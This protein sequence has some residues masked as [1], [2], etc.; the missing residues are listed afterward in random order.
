MPP[1][2]LLTH[3]LMN[4]KKNPG[5]GTEGRIWLIPRAA[6]FVLFRFY[7]QDYKLLKSTALSGGK[8]DT[9]SILTPKSPPQSCPGPGTWGR[10]QP[11]SSKS[12]PFCI[13]W[14]LV[15]SCPFLPHK[16]VLNED[17][18]KEKGAWR[19]SEITFCGFS[20]GAPPKFHRFLNAPLNRGNILPNARTHCYPGFQMDPTGCDSKAVP[21]VVSIF[22]VYR[23]QTNNNLIF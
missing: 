21:L 19:T 14:C 4:Q 6:C 1:S 20:D 12:P 7:F 8:N 5:L 11:S 17:K 18:K 3:L 16:R 2:D 9:A 13:K 23:S 15:V 10:T 22:N